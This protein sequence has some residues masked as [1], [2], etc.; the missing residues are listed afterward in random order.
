[1]AEGGNEAVGA[2]GEALAR[3]KVLALQTRARGFERVLG[4]WE[5]LENRILRDVGCRDAGR[6]PISA[7]PTP[8]GR[9]QGA[10]PPDRGPAEPGSACR[11][12]SSQR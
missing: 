5:T 9:I 11:S 7:H 12:P 1:M 4:G 6:V 10:E 8:S 3:A 2:D